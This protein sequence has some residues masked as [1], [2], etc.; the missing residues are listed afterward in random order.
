MNIA[1]LYFC[2]IK[3]FLFS[4]DSRKIDQEGK[5]PDD[6]LE[7]L[8][9]LGLFGIQVPE[10]Y[11]KSGQQPT[12]SGSLASFT[13]LCCSGRVAIKCSVSTV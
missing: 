10:D 3:I 7:K 12:W 1:Y 4:V 9:N 11:G 6:T 13:Y 2:L 8:K 5:I